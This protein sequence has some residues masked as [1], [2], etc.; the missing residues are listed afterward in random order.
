MYKHDNI[1]IYIEKQNPK[2]G[3]LYVH[4]NIYI[5]I[6]IIINK[7]KKTRAIVRVIY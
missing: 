6:Y 4:V 7:K 2:Q 1:Y 3:P 5:Y